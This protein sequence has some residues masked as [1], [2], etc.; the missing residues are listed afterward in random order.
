MSILDA[1]F[2]VLRGF[3][4]LCGVLLYGVAVLCLVLV[5]FLVSFCECLFV[6]VCPG[7]GII[8]LVTATYAGWPQGSCFS[9]V[10]LIRLQL[11]VCGDVFY[12]ILGGL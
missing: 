10:I 8:L 12:T 9:L 4:L 11:F 7:F 6:G 2:C 3:R 5:F 1:G